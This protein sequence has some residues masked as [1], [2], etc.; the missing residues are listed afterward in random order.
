GLRPRRPARP[1]V[2]RSQ[3]AGRGEVSTPRH[4]SGPWC[5]EGVEASAGM[6]I[7]IRAVALNPAEASTPPSRRVPRGPRALLGAEREQRACPGQPVGG[8]S[9]LGKRRP[10]LESDGQGPG[11]LR[12][13][14]AASLS[15]AAL[16]RLP[17][18]GY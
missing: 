1:K 16:C 3:V 4:D 5:G 9:I 12:P 11:L 8:G 17:A 18:A 6:G 13:T 15:L 2:S 7:G 14:P 10:D